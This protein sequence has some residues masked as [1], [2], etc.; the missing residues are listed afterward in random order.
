M[1]VE[2]FTQGAHPVYE[3]A[4]MALHQLRLTVGDR[5]FF[6]ILK[7]WPAAYRHR[8]ADAR[9]FIAF[10]EKLTGRDLDGLFRTW[11]YEDGR[12]EKAEG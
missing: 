7:E 8:N 1:V 2:R 11:I 10:C 4:A 9:D 12:P 3:R 5:A 6:R